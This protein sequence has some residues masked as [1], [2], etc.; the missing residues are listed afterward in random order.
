MPTPPYTGPE[1]S[2]PSKPPKARPGQTGAKN[3]RRWGQVLLHVIS[4][5]LGPATQL[6]A[7][8]L[9]ISL[10]SREVW[11]AFVYQLIF[12]S[13]AGLLLNYGNK[14]YLLRAFSRRPGQSVIRWKQMLLTRGML[15]F[16]LLPGILLAELPP[17][18]G[19]WILLWILAAWI[20]QSFDVI[21]LAE[22][23]FWP[24]ILFDLAGMLL[25]LGGLLQEGAGITQTTLLRLFALSTLL[26]A[27]LAAL[28][29]RQPWLQGAFP[30]VD[31]R[32]FRRAL[33]FFMLGMIGMLTSRADLYC[34]ALF[35]EQ[36]GELARYQVLLSILIWMQAP[37]GLVLLPFVRNLYR[38][39]DRVWR[40]VTL[41]L[42][43]LGL[44]V[45]AIGMPLVAWLLNSQLSLDFE[46]MWFLLSAA[47]ILPVYVYTTLV[48]RLYRDERQMQVLEAN[49]LGIGVN[50]GLN[51]LLIPHL[52]IQ[53]ALIASVVG[54]W[55]VGGWAFVRLKTGKRNRPGKSTVKP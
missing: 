20:R 26:R 2:P 1:A 46:P 52:G 5:L 11:G 32:L 47:Y 13:L 35:V 29:F 19:A 7:A 25:L 31:F 27:S 33:P 23:R 39:R 18:E 21:I 41:R 43:G 4:S 44:L 14:E 36:E 42:L 51:L 3:R 16:I 48:F 24:A 54:Q 55:L 37:A 6:L 22:K 38:M 10:A 9:V 49:L 12:I 28:Y 50:V 45:I 8:T 30:Q 40:G 34:V 17:E 53:G 15:L